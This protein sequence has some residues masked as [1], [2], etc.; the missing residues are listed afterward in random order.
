[1]PKSSSKLDPLNKM[2]S[3]LLRRSTWEA[4]IVVFNI[5]AIITIIDL[6]PVAPKVEIRSLFILPIVLA[7]WMMPRKQAIAATACIILAL[8]I[9]K[10]FIDGDYDPLPLAASAVA[11]LAS[12]GTVAAIVMGVRSSYNSVLH[13]ARQD[14]MTG[15]LNKTAIEE[16][17]SIMFAS[18]RANKAILLL[19]AM[20]LDRFKEVNDRHGHA[21]GDMV[22]KTFSATVSREIRRGDRFG[23][24]G[25]DEFALVVQTPSA[26]DARS[27][28]R[29]L[30]T[31]ITAALKATG[32]PVTCSMGALIVS[33]SQ[34]YPHNELMRQADDLMYRAKQ[35]GKDSVKIALLGQEENQTGAVIYAVQ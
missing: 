13:L 5:T 6:L 20:D 32:Y 19:V 4:W 25:G 12:L 33:P 1:M 35:A 15:I 29:K 10:P 14:Q 2:A 28:A 26:D 8:F 21:V 11:R 24:T 16:E 18:A 17:I 9:R 30:H 34:S 27:L 31:R 23:R 3:W 22:L 7:C